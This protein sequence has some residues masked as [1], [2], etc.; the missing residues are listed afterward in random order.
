MTR[1][2]RLAMLLTLGVASLGITAA[3]HSGLAPRNLVA[4]AEVKLQLREAH[5]K[6]L[7]I[8]ARKKVRGPLKGLTYYGSYG[9]TRY[10]IATFSRVGFGTQDQ[11]E[12]FS[13]PA[14][15]PW[16]DRGDSG[17]C[18][19]STI[20]PAPL[21]RLWGFKRDNLNPPCFQP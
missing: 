16:R 17:G 5:L 14:G 18:I 9:S 19:S 13:K 1:T 10:A 12:L 7:P 11:P 3:A 15:K 8:A 6:G 21:L 20:I 4:T 2:R